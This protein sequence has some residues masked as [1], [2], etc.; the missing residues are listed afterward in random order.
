MALQNPRLFG[1]E[2]EASL[3]DVENSS[4]ALRRLN[5]PAFDLEVIRGSAE[6]GMIRNDWYSFSR[7]KVPL[8]KTLAR[9]N[10]ESASYA[11][12]INERAGTDSILFGNLDI[13]GS[14]NG[15]AIR[16]TYVQYPNA[17]NTSGATVGIADIST[18][19]VSAWS[20]SVP[21]NLM[22]VES[23]ISYGA[24]VATNATGGEVEFGNRA[25]AL[26]FGTNSQA[27]GYRLQTTLTPLKKEFNSETPTH[28][29][30]LKVGGEYV[31]AYAMKG[32]PYVI[33]GFFRNLDAEVKI[34]FKDNKNVSWKVVEV[35]NSNS[36]T[37]YADRG[38]STS[39]IQYRS[40]V[41]RER[42]VQIYYDPDY[43][44]SIKINSG[45]ISKLPSVQLAAANSLN[46]ASNDLKNFPN[47]AFIAP[48]LTTLT[49]GGNP[50]YKSETAVERF[51]GPE[52]LDK[53][54]NTVTSLSLNSSFYGSIRGG[55]I[56]GHGVIDGKNIIAHKLP[57]L[58][59]L[60]L[61]G[62]GPYFH[63]DDKG[64]ATVPQV[65]YNIKNCEVWNNSFTTFG[66]TTN[67]HVYD[68]G[69][70]NATYPKGAYLLYKAPFLEYFRVTNNSGLGGTFSIE[71]NV[72]KEINI[73]N[74]SI[75]L[76]AA[77]NKP[78]LTNVQATYVPAFSMFTQCFDNQN[79][80]QA[81]TNANAKNSAS[82]YKLAGCD[83]LTTLNLYGATLKN[84]RFP[85]FSNASLSSL[86]LA[87][88]GIK[89]GSETGD[90]THVIPENTFSLSTSLKDITIISDL[91]LKSSISD[92][93]FSNLSSLRNL[94][95]YSYGRTTGNLPD[96]SGC[97]ALYNLNMEKNDFTGTVPM[98]GSNLSLY[99]IRLNN[100]RLSGAIPS[101]SGLGSLTYIYLYNNQLTS[102]GTFAGLG[103][104]YR[105]EAHNN[106][107]SGVIPDFTGCPN[108]YYL[109]LF[110]NQFSSYTP[111][112]FAS[113][114]KI[115]YI[116]LANNN[117][118]Q[119]SI[120]AIIT[121]LITNLSTYG[122]GRS[123]TI[124]LR[125]NATPSEEALENI[126]I[127]KDAGWSVTFS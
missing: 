70:Y 30:R 75:V 7:L 86:N 92:G 12:F 61:S 27:T 25:N 102:M 51:L 105:F 120:G 1:Y 106:Q 52:I 53:I 6:A 124:N 5:L 84:D 32:I 38:S 64:D 54:P 18:S 93:A 103:S 2:V 114:R 20:S 125:G 3:A 118:S 83:A 48:S 79:P 89:G 90:E 41:S 99:T 72:I 42:F 19:R 11:G 15:K 47:F 69:N 126:D 71:S 17:P 57:N 85:V 80:P 122:S 81:T 10:E 73:S 116:D 56:S 66:G 16:Y 8:I 115:K 111:T 123:I 77:Q 94:H 65:P 104:L 95:Y 100:N 110:N 34:N 74:T 88:T 4:L 9:Y 67:T 49:V 76:P 91:L 55:N 58:V 21:E 14:L 33:K 36:F 26:A 29:I 43:I 22:T 107:I 44:T 113:L 50:L 28:K 78:Q 98:F 109:I 37:N 23:P 59:N 127:L 24:Q 40:A 63:K 87:Y 97:T 39:S 117:L 112:S 101:F 68:A 45:N 121:D 35:A 96:F 60:Y 119:Q 13:N 31:W 108:L 62:G 46:F 82:G